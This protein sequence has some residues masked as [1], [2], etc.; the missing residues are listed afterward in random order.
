MCDDVKVVLGLNNL[1]PV[2]IYDDRIG[3]IGSSISTIVPR[4]RGSG[5]LKNLIDAVRFIQKDFA[6]A[7]LDDCNRLYPTDY[8]V[9]LPGNGHNRRELTFHRNQ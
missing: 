4:L 3:E 6:R 5:L 1:P 8:P 2:V 7:I 9:L